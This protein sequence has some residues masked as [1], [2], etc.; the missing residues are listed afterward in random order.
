[1]VSLVGFEPTPTASE[2]GTLSI[3]LQG[4]QRV[5]LPRETQFVGFYSARSTPMVK[6]AAKAAMAPTAAQTGIN[7]T[8]TR[9][10]VNGISM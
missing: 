2:A 7:A 4:Q 1:M 9:P 10:M 3:A 6:L 5:I 8:P